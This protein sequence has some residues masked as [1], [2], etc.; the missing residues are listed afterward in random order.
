MDKQYFF[1]LSEFIIHRLEGG[2][3][4]SLNL[5]VEKSRFCRF[6]E[7]K[8][9]QDGMVN[10]AIL[11][12]SLVVS[13]DNKLRQLSL[14]TSLS[15]NFDQDCQ[16]I[17]GLLVRLRNEI[18]RLPHDPYA[19]IPHFDHKSDYMGEGTLL[20]ENQV[21]NL[22]LPPL[23]NFS[24]TGLYS[25]GHIARAQANSAGSR[26]WFSS[27]SWIM[28]YSLYGT[29]ERAWKGFQAGTSWNPKNWEDETAKALAQLDALERPLK[30]LQP[31]EYRVYLSPNAVIDLLWFLGGIFGEADLRR[32]SSPLCPV[33]SGQSSFSPLFNFS[34]DF[35][36]GD[37]PRFTSEGERI[38]EATPL[39]EEGQLR[40]TLI[41]PRSSQEYGIPSNG[42][43]LSERVRSARLGTGGSSEKTFPEKD[44]LRRLDTGLYVSNLHYLNWS[45]RPEGRITG[46]TRYACF[47]VEGGRLISPIENLRWDD[48]IFRLFGS[49]V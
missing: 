44:A 28:D 47:L 20:P 40:G 41:G 17:A 42:A 24:P 13:S 4:L 36:S 49:R 3:S 12:A 7:G 27:P 14:S 18:P 1:D 39:V 15:Q 10:D 25:A 21:T 37:T 35:T 22:I 5:S 48:T 11:Q 32:G 19:R 2:E 45:N 38:P 29:G 16:K 43:D 9:R 30:R 31:G 6:N 46:M 26:H 8:I 33:Q 23:N 34:E